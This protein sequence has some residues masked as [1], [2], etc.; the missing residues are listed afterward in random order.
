MVFPAC[1][2]Y[3]MQ[4]QMKA[5]TDTKKS[6]ENGRY[7]A[8]YTLPSA[9]PQQIAMVQMGQPGYGGQPMYGQPVQ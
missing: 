9:E 5:E 7:I 3:I 8:G 4:M 2:A 1:I 6:G